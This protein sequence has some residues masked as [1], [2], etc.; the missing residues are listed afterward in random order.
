MRD[1]GK[2][3]RTGCVV[4]AVESRILVIETEADTQHQIVRITEI[5]QIVT[6]MQV[7]AA[8][9][10]HFQRQHLVDTFVV[11]ATMQ[12]VGTDTDADCEVGHHVLR[13]S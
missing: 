11:A 5:L 10:F 1:M 6:H 13:T 4:S 9:K 2:N 8:G 12:N 7:G 3:S